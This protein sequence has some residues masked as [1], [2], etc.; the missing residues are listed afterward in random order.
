MMAQPPIQNKAPNLQAIFARGLAA[1]RAG[2]LDVAAGL[3]REVLSHSRKQFAPLHLLGVIEGQR[4]NLAEG[5]RQIEKAIK[6]DPHVSDAY[7]NL[8][9]M[10]G[11]AGDLKN[12]ERNLRKAISLNSQN[13]L[14]FSNLTAVYRRMKKWDEALACADEAL[15]R[16]PG[17]EVALINRGNAFY[18]LNDLQKAKA[19]YEHVLRVNPQAEE[20]WLGIGNVENKQNRLDVA[21]LAVDRCIQINPNSAAAWNCRYRILLK[22]QKYA[23]AVS[24]AQQ[25]KKIDPDM[26]Y[27]LG[28]CYFAKVSAC[29]W[30][31]LS[32]ER[33]R[34]VAEI[35][36]GTSEVSP[37]EALVI[38]ETPSDLLKCTSNYAKK[39]G[40]SKNL[41]WQGGPYRHDRLR[42]GYVSPDYHEHAVAQLIAGVFENHDRAHFEIVGFSSGHA[43]SSGKRRRI[44]L[45]LDHFVDITELSDTAAAQ[46][47]RDMEIDIAVDL[48]GYTMGSRISVLNYRAAPVQASYLG[49]PGTTGSQSIDYLVGDKTVIPSDERKF[50]SEKIVYLPD[51]YL[52]TDNTLPISAKAPTRE[53]EGLPVK[54]FVFCGFNATF[55]ITPDIFDVW[56]R[57]LEQVPG[58]V[59]WLRNTATVNLTREAERR[60]ISSKR[61]I[62][63][64]RVETQEDHLARHRLADLF[65][66]TI[67][68]NAHT[69]ASDALWAGLPI[70]TCEGNTFAGRVAGSLLRAVGLPELVTTSLE[71]YEALALKLARDPALLASIKAKLAANRL[72]TPLFDTARYTRHLE[73]AYTT[74][75]ERAQR[76]KPPAPFAVDALP[77]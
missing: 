7:L 4:G 53:A 59:L 52:P 74:M 56:M 30:N 47:I 12:A 73:A 43:N 32:T 34:A 33:K 18:E 31:D 76:G 19:N 3:Y 41:K 21:L 22:M 14:A 8:G 2:Q 23:E 37:F 45:G 49:Y 62:F 16:K 25:A 75:W 11:E 27:L 1:H 28:A 17:D 61:L 20:A 10:Q 24:A 72:T 54:G 42:I 70:I 77:A 38:A 48:A 63:S 57:L 36:A 64:Q 66:D 69:T 44:E 39:I 51:T 50:Y 26:E 68:Y 13:A 58:S 6:I 9:R 40:L 46:R 71:D 5:I 35:R 15:A 55:K 65:L 29:D 60:G 67:Y